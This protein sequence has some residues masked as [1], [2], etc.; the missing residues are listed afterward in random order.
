[1]V[2][3][4]KKG[5]IFSLWG[6]VVAF[7]IFI[8]IA[9]T[10]LIGFN[11]M[12]GTEII[13][14]IHSEISSIAEDMTSTEIQDFID[15]SR[16]EYYNN[17]IPWDLVMFGLMI[18]FYFFIIYSAIQTK[19]A[20]S[21]TV[22]S[23]LTFGSIFMLL[24]VSVSIDVQEWILQEIYVDVFEDMSVA[25]P[26]MDWFFLNVGVVSFTLALLVVLVNQFD[27]LRTLFI[28]GSEE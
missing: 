15:D 21:F 19:K 4:N 10:M 26:I 27:K 14:P 25:T 5:S 8:A 12:A 2:L 9:F 28:G 20:S 23:L 1:M 6:M 16:T 22:F 7:N 11:N 13:D 17:T 3:N 18:N 24:L